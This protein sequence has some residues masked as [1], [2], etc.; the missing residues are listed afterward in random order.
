MT[1]R[2]ATSAKEIFLSNPNWLG[3]IVDAG[4]AEGS[5][6]GVDLVR[7]IRGR[8]PGLPLAL[9][10]GQDS[11]AIRIQAPILDVPLFLKLD[12]P[13]QFAPFLRR[14]ARYTRT[15]PERIVDAARLKFHL[16]EKQADLLA[17]VIEHG[18]ATGY[19]MDRRI[20]RTSYD[21][22]RRALLNN[23]RQTELSTLAIA[24]WKSALDEAT[25]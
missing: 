24:L 25:R 5:D 10:S 14:C 17:W 8:A 15:R 23:T 2:S 21:K 4:L 16:T 1:A 6:A 3:A 12:L 13:D 19:A 18:N 20:S 9:T 11:D 22:R 7:W